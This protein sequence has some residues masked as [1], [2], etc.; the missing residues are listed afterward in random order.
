MLIGQGIDAHR[1]EAGRRLMLGGVEVPHDQGLAAH[2]DGDVLIHALCDALLG[3]AGLGDIGHH[4]PDNDAAYAGIDSRI[5]LRR[6]MGALA[7]RDLS[8]HNVD[9]TIAAQRPKLAPYI[10]AMR[11]VLAQ[12]LGCAVARVNVKATTTERMGFTGRGE[13]IAAFAVVL[14]DAS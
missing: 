9:L 7:E 6:V 2:S 3:A 5:L 14:L 4:F 12:D 1:F 8:V 13:G 11:E 10:G